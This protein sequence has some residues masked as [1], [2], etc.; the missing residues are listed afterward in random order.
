MEE[1]LQNTIEDMQERIK[2]EQELIDRITADIKESTVRYDAKY[3]VAFMPGK[4]RELEG[5]IN[6]QKSFCDQLN[7]LKFVS[8]EQ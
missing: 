2:L 7:I 8:K 3:L 5:A 1:R 6:R 4:I